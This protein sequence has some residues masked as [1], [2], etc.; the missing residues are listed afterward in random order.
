MSILNEIED[1]VDKM[2]LNEVTNSEIIDNFLNDNFIHNKEEA[3]EK[4]RN[5]NTWSPEWGTSNV[6][7]KKMN[8]NGWALTFF[9]T[10]ILFRDNDGGV[11][12]NTDKKVGTAYTKF[13]TTID[14][15]I[16]QKPELKDK[17][18]VVNEE[19]MVKVSSGQK[20]S[21]DLFS[22]L[23]KEIPEP[24]KEEISSEEEAP[25]ETPEEDEEVPEETEDE[26]DEKGEDE[27]EKEIPEE[28]EK[29]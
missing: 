10:P 26:E 6:K 16:D 28:T 8:E 4:L 13:R 29:K 15:L 19:T 20:V 22:K 1:V 27:E 7:I 3:A 23:D 24:T 14:N 9:G 5:P 2:L 18:R 21:E 12:F 17:I 25:E 11:Y